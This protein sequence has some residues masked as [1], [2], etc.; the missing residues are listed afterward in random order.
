M[1]NMNDN[2]KYGTVGRK[3]REQPPAYHILPRSSYLVLPQEPNTTT[4][5][6]L[7]DHVGP[8]VDG[9][10]SVDVLMGQQVDTE[11]E[12]DIY[13][14]TKFWWNLTYLDAQ[15]CVQTMQTITT[16]YWCLFNSHFENVLS[17]I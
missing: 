7:Q 15:K 10:A 8:S 16:S 4:P 14:S 13:I 5:D 6:L 12:E 1:T 9:A 3:P 17:C 2:M 11:P